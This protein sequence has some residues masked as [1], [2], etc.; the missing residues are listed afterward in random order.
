MMKFIK[1]LGLSILSTFVVAAGV[2]TTS[3]NGMNSFSRVA[4]SNEGVVSQNMVNTSGVIIKADFAI[5]IGGEDKAGSVAKRKSKKRIKRRAT[6]KRKIKRIVRTPRTTKRRRAVVR[7]A[8]TQP[9]QQKRTARR[10]INQDVLFQQEAL[11]V[12]GF[13][14]GRPDG[15][16]GRRTRAAI[17]Q[18]QA[19]N[20]LVATGR[21]S[22]QGLALLNQQAA[23]VSAGGTVG[24]AA[25]QQVAIP[26]APNT[27]QATQPALVQPA[28]VQPVQVQPVP[29]QPALTQ[30]A[31]TQPAIPTQPAVSTQQVT[32]QVV[33]AEPPVSNKQNNPIDVPKEPQ[34]QGAA[35]AAQGAPQEV[36]LPPV[37][38]DVQTQQSTP[39]W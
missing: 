3:A 11:N 26:L 38:S 36:L 28:L 32:P 24:S 23:V 1:F 6:V 21:F 14:A 7:R 10:S 8:P 34:V 5:E 25:T 37:Q 16:T 31:V 19:A 12:L 27:P 17:S 29:A 2:K 18:F 39:Q 4:A 9:V 13:D 33:V 30:Q 22:P 15:V 35:A 20:G